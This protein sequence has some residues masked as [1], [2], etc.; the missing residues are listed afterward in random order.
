MQLRTYTGLWNVEKRLYKFYDVNLPYP[1]S[2]KQLGIL[3]GTAVP[4]VLLMLLVHMPLTPP[5]NILWFLPPI[6]AMIYA[7]RP[8]AEGKTIQDFVGSQIRYFAAPRSYSALKADP[9]DGL[10]TNI[11]GKFWRRYND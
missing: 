9:K 1:F 11:R 3:F 4:W 10:V 8:V 7:N 6:G 5:F 2:L